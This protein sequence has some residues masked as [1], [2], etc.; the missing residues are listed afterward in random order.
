MRSTVKSFLKNQLH[1]KNTFLST[2]PNPKAIKNP[3]DGIK[4]TKK[5]NSVCRDIRKKWDHQS[6]VYL[7][8]KWNTLNPTTNGKIAFRFS[9][10]TKILKDFI[11]SLGTLK[12][13]EI[14]EEP[15]KNR[16]SIYLQLQVK[17][18]YFLTTLVESPKMSKAPKELLTNRNDTLLT[19]SIKKK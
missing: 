19:T 17:K 10:I 5:I 9:K 15:H 16:L 14:P 12:I 18:K 6:N 3:N 4:A 11:A 2:E 7:F 1:S 13:S 8:R